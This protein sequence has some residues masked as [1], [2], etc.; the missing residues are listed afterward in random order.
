MAH[1]SYV[2]RPAAIRDKVL[3]RI[4]EHCLEIRDL[5]TQTLLRLHTRAEHPGT[6]VLPDDERVFNRPERYADA[7]AALD[8]A[9]PVA[10]AQKRSDGGLEMRLQDVRLVV[11]SLSRGESFVLP[12]S[13]LR[14]LTDRAQRVNSPRPSGAV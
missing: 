12:S 10:S 14:R 11:P 5:K 3:V 1:S 8:L 9:L 13:G 2:A 6:V 7:G 4:F